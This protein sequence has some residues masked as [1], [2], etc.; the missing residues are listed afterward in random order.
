MSLPC[1]V[2]DIARY[3]SKIAAFNLPH[4]Y[5]APPLGVTQ[6]EF[7]RYFWR[8]KTRVWRCLRDPRF[9]RF[10]TVP[11][12]DRRQTDGQTHDT[13]AYIPR[14]ASIGSRG[15]NMHKTLFTNYLTHWKLKSKGT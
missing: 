15:K 7:R 5:L 9:S 10:R 8:E 14:A 11:A 2:S 12:C 4:L 1:T 3:W 6:L 13:T